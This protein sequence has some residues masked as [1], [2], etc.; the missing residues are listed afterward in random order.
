MGRSGFLCSHLEVGQG[1]EQSRRR[2]AGTAGGW[3]T[4]APPKGAARKAAAAGGPAAGEWPA[5][6]RSLGAR[7]RGFR[8]APPNPTPRPGFRYTKNLTSPFGLRNRMI[9]G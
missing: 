2:R 6:G 5:G 1:C 8:T 3:T 9:K 4:P 7:R